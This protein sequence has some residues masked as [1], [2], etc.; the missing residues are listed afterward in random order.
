MTISRAH[1][2]PTDPEGSDDG[3]VIELPPVASAGLVAL[4]EAAAAPAQD[5]ELSWEHG[6]RTLF[7]SEVARWPRIRHRRGRRAVVAATVAV[8][9]LAGSTGLAAATGFPAPAA[10][11]VDHMFDDRSSIVAPSGT[12][13]PS[14]G[15]ASGHPHRSA[16]PAV[17]GVSAS[18]ST[19]HVVTPPC[20][21]GVRG[22]T[23]GAT[24]A[25]LPTLPCRGGETP[26]SVSANGQTPPPT[27]RAAS[28]PVSSS[29][30]TTSGGDPVISVSGASG[31]TPSTPT[32]TT[33]TTGPV[34]TT[35][36][37]TTTTVP[38]GPGNGTGRGGN[39]GTGSGSGGKKGTGPGGHNPGGPK[40]T[41][42]GG[43]QGSRGGNRGKGTS[44]GGN[45]GSGT[46]RGGSHGSVSGATGGKSGPGTTTTTTTRGGQRP[47]VGRPG[48]T[49]G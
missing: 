20:S 40:K 13:M 8:G 11:I 25:S 41:H 33:S 23:P 26:S 10:R 46:G 7:R 29:T 21:P 32:T 28:G 42:G 44:R 6:A 24:S 9:V 38:S 15:P 3:A 43:H 36:T 39:R 35:T 19:H 5:H 18:P 30:P 31:A 17:T 14:A 1:G 16:P 34:P 4:L 49:S 45:Q 37:T 12:T 22:A 47:G 2:S 48:S 27:A